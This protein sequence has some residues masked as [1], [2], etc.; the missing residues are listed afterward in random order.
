[1]SHH[2]GSDEAPRSGIF[3]RAAGALK[4]HERETVVAGAAFLAG[5]LLTVF[6]VAEAAPVVAHKDPQ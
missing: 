2:H 1:M 6:V 4:G 5:V 3:E